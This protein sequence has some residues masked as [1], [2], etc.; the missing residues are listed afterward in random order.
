MR[1][2]ICPLKMLQE[3]SQEKE[4]SRG[5]TLLEEPT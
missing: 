2:T 4:V 3:K 1:L 5:Q